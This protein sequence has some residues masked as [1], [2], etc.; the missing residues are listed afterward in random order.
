MRDYINVN[1]GVFVMDT[2]PRLLGGMSSNLCA[3]MICVA[4]ALVLVGCQHVHYKALWT[5][6]CAHAS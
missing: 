4:L 2:D 6:V 1:K 5:V 3:H